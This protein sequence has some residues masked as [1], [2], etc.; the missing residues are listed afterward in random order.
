MEGGRGISPQTQ[1]PN[2]AYAARVTGLQVK[3]N[4]RGFNEAKIIATIG[5]S[6]KPLRMNS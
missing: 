2:S 4:N 3:L 5:S 1:K 6:S